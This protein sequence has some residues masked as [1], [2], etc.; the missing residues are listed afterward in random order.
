M[1][2]RMW[3]KR[4]TSPWL[5]GLQTGTTTLEINLEEPQ[6]IEIYLPENPAISRS[7]I[8]LKDS[9][10]CHRSTCSTMF[11]VA[12]F[13]IANSWKQPKCPKTEEWIQKMWFIYA[14]EY[15]STIKNKDILNFAGKWMELENILSEVIQTQKDVHGMYSLI[16][17]Y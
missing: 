17:G 3:R 12:L 6:K 2:E 10:P 9:P 1:L 4:N 16:S 15:Y 5:V 8:Y 14:M 13:V 11:I 7:G